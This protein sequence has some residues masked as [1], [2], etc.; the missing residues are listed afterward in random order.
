MADAGA[1]LDAASRALLEEELKSPCT[2]EVGIFRLPQRI[3]LGIDGFVVLDT[4]PTGHTLL[5][6]DTALAYHRE[7]TRQVG[8]LPAAVQDLLPS[9]AETR[10][11]LASSW[12]RSPK[13][14]GSR[15]R[16]SAARPGPGGN[17]TPSPG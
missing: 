17:R 14:P 5:L 6:L 16:I 8:Q 3:S 11:S 13:L 9:I 15:S 1:D 2:A 7:V 10:T 12:S 4:A